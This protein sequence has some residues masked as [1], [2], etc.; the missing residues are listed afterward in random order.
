MK[1]ND[2]W[3]W[4]NLIQAWNE[5]KARRPNQAKYEHMFSQWWDQ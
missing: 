5:P 2:P 3:V 4:L 1:Q